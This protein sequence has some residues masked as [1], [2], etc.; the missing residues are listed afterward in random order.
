MKKIL[1]SGAI[2]CLLAVSAF[3]QANF[4]PEVK[5]VAVFK[6]GYAFTY[7]EA[8]AQTSDGWA[9]TTNAPVGVLGTV[10]GY[11]TLAL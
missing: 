2:F 6:N 5:R 7:R 1:M 3:S 11:S 4:A 9:Y 8:E 10:W